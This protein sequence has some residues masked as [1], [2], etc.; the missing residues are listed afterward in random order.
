MDSVRSGA[1]APRLGKRGRPFEAPPDFEPPPEPGDAG[2]AVPPP[3]AAVPGP[4]TSSA[5]VPPVPKRPRDEPRPSAAEPVEAASRAEEGRRGSVAGPATPKN[6]RPSDAP[7]VPGSADPARSVS[8]PADVRH[9]P[10]AGP[11][12]ERPRPSV[13]AGADARSPEAPPPD[14]T[15][16]VAGPAWSVSRAGDGLREPAVEPSPRV[17]LD[18]PA[19]EDSRPSAPGGASSGAVSDGSAAVFRGGCG[20]RGGLLGRGVKEARRASVLMHPP[21]PRPGRCVPRGPVASCPR[22]GT[23]SS[24]AHIPVRT[25]RHP[26]SDPRPARSA[27]RARH[28]TACSCT[29]GNQSTTPGHLPGT[30]PYPAV[31]QSGR[32][33]S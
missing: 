33:R 13:S 28:S 14:D 21:F 31:I 23:E 8:R 15:R 25:E 16:P 7:R 6:P 5:A 29:N 2:P 27:V 24:R 4:V 3:R 12:P 9:D 18:R 17:V 19:S 22:P 26:G 11:P 10:A 20:G 30:S 1:V 32:L